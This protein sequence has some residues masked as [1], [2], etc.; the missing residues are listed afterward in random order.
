MNLVAKE[1]VSARKD[2]DGVLVLSTFTGASR[3]LTDALLVNPYDLDECAVQLHHALVM[4]SEERTQRMERM[5]MTV[6]EKNIY[7]WAGA[8]LAETYHISQLKGGVAPI[9][10]HRWAS[11]TT[12]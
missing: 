12:R 4:P 1:Y 10:E 11:S 6:S 9:T 7:A 8:I 3:E 2:N 5:R